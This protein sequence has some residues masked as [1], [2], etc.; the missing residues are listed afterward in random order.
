M[1]ISD[2]DSLFLEDGEESANLIRVASIP[3]DYCVYLFVLSNVYV[4]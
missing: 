3:G 1:L 4:G 2:A